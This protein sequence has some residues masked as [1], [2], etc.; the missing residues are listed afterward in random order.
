MCASSP[1]L[2]ISSPSNVTDFAN[3]CS[4]SY[5]LQFQQEH[6]SP[7]PIFSSAEDSVFRSRI[8]TNFSRDELL[9]VSFPVSISVLDVL[10]GPKLFENVISLL[11]ERDFE[12][13]LFAT[14]AHELNSCPFISRTI[15][16]DL[17]KS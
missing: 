17:R 1:K 4:D 16:Q 6:P 15:V 10:S 11:R 3:A 13:K 14:Q 12:S 2:S 8:I 9:N 5:F 7:Y